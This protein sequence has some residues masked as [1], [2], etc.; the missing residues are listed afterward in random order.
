MNNVVVDLSRFKDLDFAAAI[1]R[2]AQSAKDNAHDLGNDDPNYK[3]VIEEVDVENKR[4]KLVADA[5][6]T[7]FWEEVFA[8]TLLDGE[9]YDRFLE[10]KPLHDD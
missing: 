3:T 7:M 5:T 10:G 6:E 8:Y 1:A 4:I 9:S 2:R